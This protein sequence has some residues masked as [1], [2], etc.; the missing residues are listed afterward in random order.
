MPWANFSGLESKR[1]TKLA[2]KEGRFENR[3]SRIGLR[4]DGTEFLQLAGVDMGLQRNRVFM[5]D[6]YRCQG[7]GR[8]LTL[9]E[10]EMDHVRSRGKGGDDSMSNLRTVCFN[11]HRLKHVRI[12]SGKVAVPA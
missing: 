12:L 3:S 6:N 5:R 2:R 4:P 9:A 1:L 10:C 11:C 8:A 7:C